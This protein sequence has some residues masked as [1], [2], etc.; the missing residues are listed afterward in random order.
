MRPTQSRSRKLDRE[1]AIK[2][3]TVLDCSPRPRQTP[4]LS[5]D[6]LFY[7]T[8]TNIILSISPDINIS[9]VGERLLSA[10]ILQD[11]RE[12]NRRSSRSAC[13][14]NRAIGV[15]LAAM[16]LSLIHI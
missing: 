3:V 14:K 9:I 10:S 13:F 5:P 11:V 15:E 12:S 4:F 7:P 6:L 16:A 1:K 8:G 2:I